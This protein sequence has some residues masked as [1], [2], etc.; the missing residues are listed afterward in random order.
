MAWAIPSKPC[1]ASNSTIESSA[2]D[3][4]WWVI[5]CFLSLLRT[6]RI[7]N[8][9]DPPLSSP[10]RR[11]LLASASVAALPTLRLTT[12]N[13]FYRREVTLARVPSHGSGLGSTTL[14]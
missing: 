10:S 4:S 6:Q 5:A 1:S 9:L 11:L 3:C 8:R 14:L 2:L 7:G 13:H 12:S